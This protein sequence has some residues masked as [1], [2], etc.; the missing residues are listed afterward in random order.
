MDDPLCQRCLRSHGAAHV[1]PSG[2]PL[3]S[4]L[5]HPRLS[6]LGSHGTQGAPLEWCGDG[7]VNSCLPCVLVCAGWVMSAVYDLRVWFY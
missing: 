4:A 3:P 1:L 2:V 7:C 5:L 6:P